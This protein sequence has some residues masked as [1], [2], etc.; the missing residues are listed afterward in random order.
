MLPF[1]PMATVVLLL[2]CRLRNRCESAQ[3]YGHHFQ[4]RDV[5]STG[6]SPCWRTSFK[7]SEHDAKVTCWPMPRS[8]EHSETEARINAWRS[9][10]RRRLKLLIGIL[11]RVCTPCTMRKGWQGSRLCTCPRIDTSSI[12]DTC[13]VFCA[14]VTFGRQRLRTFARWAKVGADMLTQEQ[15]T[16]EISVTGGG[17]GCFTKSP[18]AAMSSNDSR[19][20]DRRQRSPDINTLLD[21][22][23]TFKTL[24][25]PQR[26]AAFFSRPPSQIGLTTAWSNVL[27]H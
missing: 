20:S 21:T 26:W 1:V 23:P 5:P 22:S 27:E 2:C 19:N 11:S 14:S 8:P 15:G 13:L 12:V 10:P 9:G 18:S 25:F 3:C 7:D 16:D 17:E 4:S 24:R 6:R